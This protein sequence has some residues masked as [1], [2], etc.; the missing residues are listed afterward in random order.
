MAQVVGAVDEGEEIVE[1]AVEEEVVRR[2]KASTERPAIEILQGLHAMAQ[3]QLNRSPYTDCLTSSIRTR[4]LNTLLSRRTHPI[5][6]R[7]RCSLMLLQQII[8][9][10]NSNNFSH[11][12]TRTFSLRRQ[13]P[14]F[15]LELSSIL[16]SSR[17]HPRAIS[18][19]RDIRYRH[20]KVACPI[21]VANIL[22]SMDH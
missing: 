5:S 22:L 3:P 1:E 8:P 14:E 17:S 7:C 12:F 4:R 18:I 10:T 13:K 11:K 2:I 15:P 16:H 9:A 21:V 19:R 20:S 6:R